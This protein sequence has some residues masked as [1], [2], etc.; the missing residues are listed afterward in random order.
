MLCIIIDFSIYISIIFFGNHW[1]SSLYL[2]NIGSL[3]E[4]H[5]ITF[6]PLS[7]LA[8]IAIA[9]LHRWEYITKIGTI[10][11][12]AAELIQPQ[13]S[14]VLFLWRGC[15]SVVVIYVTHQKDALLMAH[16]LSWLRRT[17]HSSAGA[18]HF[19]SFRCT[20]AE[21]FH[22]GAGRHKRIDLDL[23]LAWT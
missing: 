4:L 19:H 14:L 17:N 21:H 18:A 23:P 22:P 1:R 9:K 16:T 8:S 15:R 12:A 11:G 2:L 6:L 7:S 20:G 5:T 10:C 13:K 3:P